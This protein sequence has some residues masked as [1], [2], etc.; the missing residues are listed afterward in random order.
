MNEVATRKLHQYRR[1]NLENKSFEQQALSFG[2]RFEAREI[3]V[4]PKTE[5]QLFRN[6]DRLGFSKE[7]YAKKEKTRQR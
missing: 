2:G 1:Q 3:E 5:R 7:V 6:R 4:Q